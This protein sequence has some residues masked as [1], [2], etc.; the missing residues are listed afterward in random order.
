MNNRQKLRQKPK[1]IRNMLLWQL[2]VFT[3]VR[4]L[5]SESSL[6]YCENSHQSISKS[7]KHSAE[8]E[9]YSTPVTAFKLTLTKLIKNTKMEYSDATLHM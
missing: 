5:T 4:F 7:R 9:S 8:L 6:M 3:Y 2:I 1:L